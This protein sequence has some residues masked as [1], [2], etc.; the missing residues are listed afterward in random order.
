MLAGIRAVTD[1]GGAGLCARFE[2]SH[3][4]IEVFDCILFCFS[5]V[6]ESLKDNF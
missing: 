3:K 1:V 6:L 2:V 4:I 5:Q